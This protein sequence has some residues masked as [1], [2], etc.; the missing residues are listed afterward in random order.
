MEL[1]LLC[2][3]NISSVWWK[4]EFNEKVTFMK[5][6]ILI[7]VN[8]GMKPLLDTKLSKLLNVFVKSC[9]ILILKVPRNDTLG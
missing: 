3:N 6:L 9:M 8:L 4:T 2:R 1:I 7:L 5:V